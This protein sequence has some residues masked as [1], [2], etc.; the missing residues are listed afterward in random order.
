MVEFTAVGVNSTELLIDILYLVSF[1]VLADLCT[2]LVDINYI[3][4]SR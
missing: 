2:A 3:G 4:V 1:F